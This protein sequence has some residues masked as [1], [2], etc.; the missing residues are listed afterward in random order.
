[1]H[2]T[3]NFERWHCQFP[4][5]SR[6]SVCWKSKVLK[7]WCHQSIGDIPHTYWL[8]LQKL[9]VPFISVSI[10]KRKQNR[11][12]KLPLLEHIIPTRPGT[13]PCSV[14]QTQRKRDLVFIIASKAWIT[15][16]I[17][18]GRS[19]QSH[20]P[21]HRILYLVSSAPGHERICVLSSV[22][23]SVILTLLTGFEPTGR[24][25]CASSVLGP[26]YRD[27]INR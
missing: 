12:Y 2:Y 18:P 25:R 15:V 26:T 13:H 24:S 22:S 6:D 9:H 11:F 16:S 3:D 23:L 17:S 20:V 1:M 21:S 8:L 19:P 5:S 7:Q 10:I 27:R 4:S 14:E